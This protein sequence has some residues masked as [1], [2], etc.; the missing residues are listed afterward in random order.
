MV[1]TPQTWTDGAAGATP[2][3]AA[4]MGVIETGLVNSLTTADAATGYAIRAPDWIT[5]R[6]YI[7]GELVTNAGTLYRT[8]TAHTSGAT[9]DATKFTAIGGGGGAQVGKGVV[10]GPGGTVGAAF[11]AATTL[12]NPVGTYDIYSGLVTANTTVTL[13]AASSGADALIRMVQNATGGFTITL[14]SPGG[15]ISYPAGPLTF[16]TA[17]NA[18][19]EFVVSSPDGTNFEVVPLTGVSNPTEQVNAVGAAG[20]AQTLPDVTVATI[21][22]LTLTAACTLTFPAVV[23]GKS[24]TLVLVQDATGG[25]TVV[26]P[27]SVV[28][29]GGVTPTL[30]ATANKRDVFTF[31]S[32]DGVSWFGF[33]AGL[34]F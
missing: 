19:N 25:R 12:P 27:A 20:A 4:R 24:L 7:V 17:A 1:Y 30:T 16:L 11:P 21:N 29:A 18:V 23:A 8:T 3:S 9:F 6:A 22:R 13:F 2:L 31:L 10:T 15:T 5:G 32:P 26:Y 28:W 34:N 33:T 14:A